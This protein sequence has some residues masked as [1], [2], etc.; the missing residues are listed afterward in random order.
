MTIES[1]K[2]KLFEFSKESKEWIE[3]GLGTLKLNS[4]TVNDSYSRISTPKSHETLNRKDY[5]YVVMRADGVPRVLLNFRLYPELKVDLAQPKNVRLAIVEE[6]SVRQIL[7]RVKNGPIHLRNFIYNSIFIC[8]SE[9]SRKRIS[10]SYRWRNRL[11]FAKSLRLNLI[12]MFFKVIKI[13]L[14]DQKHLDFQIHKDPI[15]SL[16]S[17]NDS[18]HQT[19]LIL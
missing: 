5:C 11:R 2:T 14:L 19:R 3:K 12:A 15:W 16:D 8:S 17:L 10:L 4:C 7:L 1:F 18:L 9:T 13:F 6:G